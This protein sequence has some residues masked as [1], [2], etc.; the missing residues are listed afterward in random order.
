MQPEQFLRFKQLVQEAQELP[1]GEQETFLAR[2]CADDPELRA[3][4]ASFLAGQRQV[5]PDFLQ[6]PALGACL[7]PVVQAV[8]KMGQGST[9]RETPLPHITPQPGEATTDERTLPQLPQVSGYEV[10]EELGRG[11]MGVVYKARQVGL[12]R[13]VVLKMI[14]SRNGPTDGQLA[15]FRREAEVIA[16]LEHPHIVPV[17]AFGEHEGEPYFALKYVEGGSLA[18]KLNGSPWRPRQAAALVATLAGAVEYAHQQGILHRDLKPANVL[19]EARPDA[20]VQQWWPYVTDFGLARELQGERLTAD[21]DVLGT[22]AYMASEQ[23]RGEVASLKP[24][25]DVFGLGAILYQL[26]TGHPPYRGETQ[27]DVVD[28]AIRGVVTPPRQVR[29]DVP[30]RRERICLKALAA[31]PEQRYAT[32]AALE[33]DLRRWCGVPPGWRWRRGRRRC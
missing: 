5:P 13:T 3:E 4:A 32:P 23:A 27:M 16:K 7:E 21:G 9:S 10:L 20:P 18:S 26:L 8:R 6:E 29:P 28:Q 31:D 1:P 15:R 17:Y 2:A 33:R 25:T 11:G 24:W 19:L 14:L 30:R 12:N 22:P